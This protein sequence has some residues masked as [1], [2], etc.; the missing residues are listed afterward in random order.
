MSKCQ[1][2]PQAKVG[3]FHFYQSSF[4]EQISDSLILENRVFLV[5]KKA[6]VTQRGFLGQSL[7]A[8]CPLEEC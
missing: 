2:D 1:S 6:V 7:P 4:K 8:V 5:N 3:V